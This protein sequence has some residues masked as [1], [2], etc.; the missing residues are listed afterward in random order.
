MDSALYTGWHG[1]TRAPPRFDGPYRWIP[2][3]GQIMETL[4]SVLPL[5]IAWSA[6]SNLR[7]AVCGKLLRHWQEKAETSYG[8][9]HW[10][11]WRIK[12]AIRDRLEALL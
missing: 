8:R 4:R 5:V 2:V 6:Y 11:C 10:E 7:C 1:P 9:C 3:T 12:E